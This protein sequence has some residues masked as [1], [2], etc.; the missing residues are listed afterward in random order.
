LERSPGFIDF[1][2]MT[3]QQAITAVKT[4]DT[5]AFDL[6][7]QMHKRRVFS[8]CMRMVGDFGL[9]EDL[10]QDAFLMAFRRIN[11]F[12]G[13]SAFSTWLHRIAVNT[14]LMHLRQK[15][16]R[17]GTQ[18]SLDDL[19][20]DGEPSGEVF[21]KEDL[22]LIHAIDRLSLVHAIEQLPPGYRMIFVLHD[23]E[24]YDHAEIAGLL[25]CSVGNTKSQLH[26]ARLR[27]RKVLQGEK[28]SVPM[29]EV[30]ARAA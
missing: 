19:T 30:A 21:G 12:R 13:D 6:L 29:D 20:A 18:P 10:T 28:H 5:G 8:L 22:R 15:N 16:S 27:L 11:S 17:G 24:G 4:G 25:G 1:K 2:M 14:V 9:A 3:D 23:I 26:K 7:Y